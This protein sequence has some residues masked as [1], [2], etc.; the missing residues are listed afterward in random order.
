MPCFSPIRFENTYQD[1]ID[2]CDV[3]LLSL[4]VY[5]L[6]ESL[7]R[8]KCKKS[9]QL[10]CKLATMSVLIKFEQKTLINCKT[11]GMV[12]VQQMMGNG[13]VLVAIFLTKIQWRFLVKTNDYLMTFLHLIVQEIGVTL[14]CRLL[15]FANNLSGQNYQGIQS[16]KLCY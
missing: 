4:L 16:R 6:L 8:I 14:L 1:Q 9:V 10:L 2:L 15:S 3:P 11:G 12:Q 13:N 7:D 5:G